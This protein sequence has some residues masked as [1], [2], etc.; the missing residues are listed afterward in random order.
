MKGTLTEAD[1]K[2]LKTDRGQPRWRNAARWERNS[3][4]EEG[5]LKSD[6][7]WGIWEITEAGRMA[8]TKEVY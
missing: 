1:Y 3:M 7:P 6:S 8:I 5:L 4:V 2:P